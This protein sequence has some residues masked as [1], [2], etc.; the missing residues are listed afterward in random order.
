MYI[1]ASRALVPVVSFVG[2]EVG[3]VRIAGEERADLRPVWTV[4]IGEVVE[5]RKI[6]GYGWKAKLVVRW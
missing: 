4:A 2:R 3:R 6:G 1:S 5:L